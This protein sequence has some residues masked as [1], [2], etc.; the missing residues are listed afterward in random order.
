MKKIPAKLKFL[1]YNL[2]AAVVLICGITIYVLHW[3][4]DYTEH[5][6]FIV[7]PEL[8]S[9][10]PEE[11]ANIAAQSRLRV[12]VID[13]LYDA[14]ARPGTVVEQ[15]P[16]AGSHVK[17]DRMIHLTIN[18]H[19][20]EKIVFP[21]LQNA[22]FRQTMQTLEARGFKIGKIEFEPSEFQ[23]LVVG[24]KNEGQLITSG[25]MLPK[26]ATIDIVL[27][28]GSGHSSV[29]VPNL[30]GKR[31]EDAINLLHTSYLNIG[32]IIPDGTINEK[33]NKNKAFIY[34]Q[35]PDHL[36]PVEKGTAVQLYITQDQ[37]KLNTADSL[38][39]TE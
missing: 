34:Q 3:L 28:S 31:L 17:E 25:S 26:G 23:N 32:E 7:V 27:G 21:N 9:Y 24:L 16:E 4:E 19:N 38:M 33:T 37:A 18:A 39:T 6:T 36:F 29:A 13:S 10:T 15:N 1:L 2:A 8:Y 14:E 12:Q 22:A 35:S 11:A 20:P 5:G 30:T